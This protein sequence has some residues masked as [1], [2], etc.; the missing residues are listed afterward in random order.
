MGVCVMAKND[1]T[2][3]E[4]PRTASSPP[5]FTLTPDCYLKSTRNLVGPLR[6]GTAPGVGPRDAPSEAFRR[7]DFR[8]DRKELPPVDSMG[9]KYPEVD[10]PVRM[11]SDEIRKR[12]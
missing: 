3:N 9:Q 2:N 4:W 10:P 7:S 12:R 5:A 11:I 1:R 8:M 6:L